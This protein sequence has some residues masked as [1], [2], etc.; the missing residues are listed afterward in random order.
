MLFEKIVQM[1]AAESSNRTIR[2]MSQTLARVGEV[3]I[4]SKASAGEEK[5]LMI[6]SLKEIV[7]ADG[8]CSSMGTSDLVGCEPVHVKL[9]HKNLF[10]NTYVAGGDRVDNPQGK[11]YIAP[12]SLSD[13]TESPFPQGHIDYLI[14][15]N[16]KRQHGRH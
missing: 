1:L 5:T 7:G 6:M 11:Q 10:S 14:P 9:Y 8:T 4:P 3:R 15:T 2:G 12:H 13:S 16:E